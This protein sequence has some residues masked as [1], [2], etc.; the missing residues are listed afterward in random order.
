MNDLTIFNFNNKEVRT[1]L[2][3][4]EAWFIAK[5]V[6]DVLDLGNPSQALSRLD[7]DEKNTITLN[8]GIGNPEKSI[9]NEYGLYSLVLSSRKKEAKEFKRWVT[10]EVLPSIRKHGAYATEQTVERM[11]NDPDFAIKLLTTLKEERE[12]R[13][14]LEAQAEADKPKVL[15]ANSVEASSTSILIGELAKLI[16]QNGVNIG[17]NRLFDILRNKGF[18]IKNGE[19]RNMPTQKAMELKLFEVA[20]RTIN[21]PDGSIRIT[22]TTKVTGKGQVYFINYFVD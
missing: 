20:E 13:K 18:L 22:K 7:D 10:H 4:N 6:C 16:K 11:I 9:V 21:N 3:N 1:I 12:Q 14:L 17:Q 2:I 15:F 5:D 8:E 19:S